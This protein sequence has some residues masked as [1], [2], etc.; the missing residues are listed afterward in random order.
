MSV[1]EGGPLSA[2]DSKPRVPAAR[3]AYDALSVGSLGLEMGLAV[4]VGWWIG[5]WLDN[6]F[7]T[8]PYLMLLFLGCGIAAAFKA[9]F[10]AARQT[11]R[12][13]QES[14]GAREEEGGPAMGQGEHAAAQSTQGSAAHLAE[15]S[16]GHQERAR[17]RQPEERS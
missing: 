11:K 9:L 12:A 7:G 15:H 1:G 5:Q 13:A 14:Q 16:A 4:F 6:R 2:A 8:K 10:R 17:S 3:K